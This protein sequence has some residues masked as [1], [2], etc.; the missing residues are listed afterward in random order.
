MI[1]VQNL[2]LSKLKVGLLK[3][4]KTRLVMTS[5]KIADTYFGRFT[6]LIIKIMQIVRLVKTTGNFLLFKE[7]KIEYFMPKTCNWNEYKGKDHGR[8][9]R[10]ALLNAP[11]P[12]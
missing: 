10:K 9:V 2:Y 5:F 1:E 3:I 11:P 6:I 4:E 12:H 7:K 8:A